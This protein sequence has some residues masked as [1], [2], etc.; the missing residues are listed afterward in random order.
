MRKQKQFAFVNVNDG[1]T[2]HGMQVLLSNDIHDSLTAGGSKIT[3]GSSVEI[4]GRLVRIP[5]K[6]GA[7]STTTPFHQLYEVHADTARVVGEVCKS[8]NEMHRQLFYTI[9]IYCVM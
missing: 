3:T 7:A 1:S 4:N 9:Y 6:H 2:L 8:K 5:S